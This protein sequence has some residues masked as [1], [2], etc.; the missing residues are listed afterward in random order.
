[1][2]TKV[3]MECSECHSRNYTMDKNKQT[4]PERLEVNKYCPKDKKMTLH[5]ETK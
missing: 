4:H 2:R 5:K 3:T 1:M